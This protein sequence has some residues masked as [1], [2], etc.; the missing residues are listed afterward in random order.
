M[1]NEA[2]KA[3]LAD[4]MDS[5]QAG[6]KS[7][8]RAQ[9]RQAQ[10]MASA[11]AAGKRVTVVVNAKG[12]VI[13]T[14][15]AADIDDLAY[16]EIARAVTTAAQEAA[17]EVHRKTKEMVAELTREQSRLPRLSEFIP[18]MPDVQDMI[19]AAPEVSTEPPAARARARAKPTDEAVTA[20]EFT[21]VEQ[22]DH[23][24]PPSAQPNVAE[25]G[26]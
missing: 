8:Q 5:V 25:S 11:S 18:G 20:L 4:L 14:R 15:F 10:L 24:E 17:A 22:F 3:R 1:A 19:P 21:G 16:P 9:H 12:V 13:E 7:I 26:W 6:I 23:D 2:A